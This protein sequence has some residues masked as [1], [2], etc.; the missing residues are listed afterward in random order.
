M[1]VLKTEAKKLANPHERRKKKAVQMFRDGFVASMDGT[2]LHFKVRS[3]STDKEDGLGWYVVGLHLDGKIGHCTCCD[4][5]YN[6]VQCKHILA[7]RY[8]RHEMGYAC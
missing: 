3:Q 8:M 6:D 5:V 7:S 1:I 4:F 2:G